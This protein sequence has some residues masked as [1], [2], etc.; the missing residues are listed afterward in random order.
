MLLGEI[1]CQVLGWEDGFTEAAR[2]DSAKEDHL[3]GEN[4]RDCENKTVLGG[5]KVE[6]DLSHIKL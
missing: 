4:Y 3:E 2:E 6:E 5:D 1:V